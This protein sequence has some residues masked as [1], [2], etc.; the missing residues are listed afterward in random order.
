MTSLVGS[1]FFSWVSACFNLVA[2]KFSMPL[3]KFNFSFSCS[4]ATDSIKDKNNMIRPWP[5]FIGRRCT[6]TVQVW[7]WILLLSFRVLQFGCVEMLDARDKVLLR[8]LS[9]H[10]YGRGNGEMN[11]V[12]QTKRSHYNCSHCLSNSKVRMSAVSCGLSPIYH[13]S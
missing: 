4:M 9:R 7:Q 13:F 8:F 11:F 10:I 5:H 6:L 2:S 12:R 3:M 1:G